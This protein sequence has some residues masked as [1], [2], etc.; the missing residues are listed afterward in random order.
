MQLQFMY[1]SNPDT[2]FVIKVYTI[3]KVNQATMFLFFSN[4]K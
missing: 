2:G 3:K 4:C 1:C